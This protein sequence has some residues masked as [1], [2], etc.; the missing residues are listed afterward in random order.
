MNDSALPTADV[1]I[2]ELAPLQRRLLSAAAIGL[3]L[4]AV[5]AFFNVGAFLQAY[6]IAYMWCLGA[7][8]GWWPSRLTD[9]TTS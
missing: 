9:P 8:L 7:T 4:S 1:A 2:P 5:G 3:T 6:L